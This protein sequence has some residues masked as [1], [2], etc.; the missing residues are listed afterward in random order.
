MSGAGYKI[1]CVVDG[2]VGAYLL[3]KPSTF[4]WDTCAPHAILNSLGGGLIDLSK[5]ASKVKALRCRADTDG[6]LESILVECQIAYDKVG[7]HGAIQEDFLLTEILLLP[8]IYS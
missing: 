6:V 7:R 8:S 4:K 3:S 2:Q 5:A 1:L